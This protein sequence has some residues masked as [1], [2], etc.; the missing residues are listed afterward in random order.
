[1]KKFDIDSFIKSDKSKNLSRQ[2]SMSILPQDGY[3]TR[4]V[5][6]E[7]NRLAEFSLSSETPYKRMAE[8][9]D[10]KVFHYWEVLG[11]NAGEID[12][13][14]LAN[15]SNL[16]LN[17][18]VNDPNELCLGLIENVTVR[19]NRIIEIVRFSDNPEPLK[20]FNDI[21]KKIRGKVSVGYNILKMVDTGEMLEDC[22]VY[23]ATLWL[24][25]ESSVVGVA[26]DDTIGFSRALDNLEVKANTEIVK[27][28]DAVET[29]KVEA[30]EVETVGSQTE[31]KIISEVRKMEPSTAT[32][33]ITNTA[34][35]TQAVEVVKDNSKYVENMLKIGERMGKLE[36]AKDFIIAK[37]S[38]SDFMDTVTG[39]FEKDPQSFVRK[40]TPLDQVGL[41]T[42]E[43]KKWSIINHV[44]NWES[45]RNGNGDNI[46]SF[47]KDVSEQVEKQTGKRANGIWMPLDI[48]V[49]KV[50]S[51]AM[52]I[53]TSS[54][55]GYLQATTLRPD[56]FID[57]LRNADITSQM[58]F[59]VL[60]GLRGIYTIPRRTTAAVMAWIAEN[61]SAA[62]STAVY[63]LVTLTAKTVSGNSIISREQRLQ[64]SPDAEA[65]AME[66]LAKGIALSQALAILA[67]T[68]ASNQ[69]T[70]I[71]TQSSINS[72]SP[73]ANGD[74]PTWPLMNQMIKECEIDNV[75]GQLKLIIN[76]ATKYALAITPKVTALDHYLLEGGTVANMPTFI[77]NMMPSTV[78]KGSSGATLSKAVALLPSDVLV[79][80]WSGLDI[81]VDPFTYS[82]DGRV[83]INAFQDMDIQLRH[84]ESVT[85]F[86]DI[87]TT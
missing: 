2:F 75:V 23:R 34:T 35:T 20:V 69:P 42:A 72:I 58:G 84:P 15:G 67:G 32:A 77:T 9:P 86:A 40:G 19:D 29:I 1:M 87:I 14:R 52:S 61:G 37:R 43:V 82:N 57:V 16:F 10:G 36:M 53:G 28:L 55:G 13:S 3:K 47:E 63:D 48:Q 4:G 50:A 27:P 30:K 18:I 81:L 83:R 59:T 66:D 41:T 64:G 26:A 74:A 8:T 62:E 76:A 38:E 71:L 44:N 79:G 7:P 49:N 54:A 51:R 22:P 68:G 6:D 11:H 21:N 17:H 39:L 60:E 5:F 24:P 33:T 31:I 85:V 65:L 45:K 12:F 46:K 73:S 78:T 25:T 56:L 70:G 80:K